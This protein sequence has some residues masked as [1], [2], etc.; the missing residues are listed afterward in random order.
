[1]SYIKKE[2][3]KKRGIS[4]IVLM[5]TIAIIL[6]LLTTIVFSFDNVINTTKKRQF[7]KEIFE[8]QNMLDKYNYENNDYPYIVEDGENKEITF[9]IPDNFDQFGNEDK[10]NHNVQLYPIDLVKLGV[11]NLSRGVKK[12][13][14]EYDIYAFSNK[15]GKV[16]YLKG[17]KVSNKIY[18]TLTDELKKS[19]GIK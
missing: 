13:N 16:Y 8:I 12:D 2:K 18:Y 17:F 1:M 19:I 15:T 9:D 7:A 10:S 5:I 4:L 14:N 6:I 3:K 11:Q